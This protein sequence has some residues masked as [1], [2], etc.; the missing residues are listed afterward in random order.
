MSADAEYCV[1]CGQKLPARE[2]Y[3]DGRRKR[4][5]DRIG[6]GI[7]I[8]L[9]L[10]GVLYY[11]VRPHE[12]AHRA[13]PPSGGEM[14]YLTPLP[15]S[16]NKPRKKAEAAKARPQAR[17]AVAAITPPAAARPK[18]ETYVPPVVA[19]MQ[20]PPEQDL[21]ELIAKRRAQRA[22]QNP[23][24]AEPVQESEHDR[25]VR[26]A[27]ANIAG[28]QG[29]SSGSD[30]DETGGLFSLVNQGYHSAD[31][32]FRG[33]NANF[34]R[35]WTQQVHVEQGAEQDI[36]TAIVK[37]MIE[38]IRKEKTGDFPWESQRLGRVVTMSARQA[39]EAELTAFLLKEMFPEYRRGR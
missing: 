6:I 10:L 18:L 7:S 8:A 17:Q 27:K 14:V 32:K 35:N 24:P 2:G 34:K 25:G 9:H 3:G 23:Q 1:S 31:V 15:K 26:I 30:R 39:D 22:A 5:S 13:P 21:S 28:A 29:R 37:K 38:I 12:P 36:E 11:F 19:P 33:W 16:P 20:P 4:M